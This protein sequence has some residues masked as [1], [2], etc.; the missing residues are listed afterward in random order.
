MS[1][2]IG[3]FFAGIL[4]SQTDVAHMIE[5]KTNSLTQSIFAPVFFVS[6]GLKLTLSGLS[7]HIWLI[8]AFTLL[9]IASKFIGGFLGARMNG[10]NPM[11]SAIIGTSMESRGEMALILLS[12]GLE[13][14]SIQSE[15][16]GALVIVIIASTIIAPIMLKS[17]IIK[18]R[19]TSV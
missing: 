18:S 3:A 12:L 19:E 9:A 8:V 2:I 7:N 16:Y 17:L 5:E 10:F 1:D 14:G 6:I 13:T 4:I 11:S 15:I